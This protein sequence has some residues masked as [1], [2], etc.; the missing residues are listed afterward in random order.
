M[1]EFL[2][3]VNSCYVRR[4]FEGDR[5]VNFEHLDQKL[6]ELFYKADLPNPRD[7][8]LS[9][10]MKNKAQFITILYTPEN[11]KDS[12]LPEVIIINYWSIKQR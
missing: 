3:R 7:H 12:D 2:H 1:A 4:T 11:P 10:A 6:Y 5:P 9:V 8:A